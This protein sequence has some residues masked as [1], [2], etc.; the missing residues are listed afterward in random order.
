MEPTASPEDGRQ[1]RDF[2]RFWPPT[3]PAPARDSPLTRPTPARETDE[4]EIGGTRPRLGGGEP[5]AGRGN[6]GG[7][8]PG[9]YKPGGDKPGGDKPG[10]GE[11]GAGDGVPGAGDGVPGAGDG[12]PGAGGGVPGPGSAGPRPSGISNGSRW[13]DQGGFHP[14]E[15]NGHRNGQTG[16]RHGGRS[17]TNGTPLNG[18]SP[19]INGALP[20]SRS[21]FAPPPET[22]PLYAPSPFAAAGN[23][24]LPDLPADPDGDIAARR[25][26]SGPPAAG[27]APVPP[28]TGAPGPAAAD[29]DRYATD[30]AV[31]DP[32]EAGREAQAPRRESRDAGS[33]AHDAWALPSHGDAAVPGPLSAADGIP[34]LGPFPGAFI[35]SGGDPLAAAPAAE[36][37]GQWI[38]PETGAGTAGQGAVPEPAE[39]HAADQEQ[40][41]RRRAAT[42]GTTAGA[43]AAGGDDATAGRPGSRRAAGEGPAGRRAA[44]DGGPLRP[45]DLDHRPIAFWDEAAS[46]RFRSEWHEV[47][48]LFVDD[49]AAALA[50]AHDLLTEAAHELTES[51]LRQRDELDP[52]RGTAM[53]D[54]ESM[55]MAMRGYR[56]FL[57]RILAL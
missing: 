50:R 45:G 31:Q 35:P 46:D 30:D 14:V 8:R 55:R 29:E 42:P 53:P 19:A 23:P 43:R 49:P 34:A 25:P 39:R 52:M 13:N 22:P 48:A 9:G 28:L 12:V 24:L 51:M 6:P 33:G 3:G 27:S 1:S 7:D 56:E 41:A 11:P 2:A 20:M 54:T 57:D 44:E 36:Q 38:R 32:R 4:D 40:A 37:A 47:K 17:Q 26:V 16:P 10:G 5:G 21:P 15:T 18:Q